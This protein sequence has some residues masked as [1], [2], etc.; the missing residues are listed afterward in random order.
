[1]ENRS[2]REVEM[3]RPRLRPGLRFSL[4]ET[5]GRRVC[6]I[7]DPVAS[8]FHR[9][10]LAEYRFFRE[11]DGAR[12]VASILARLARD[13]GGESFTEQEALQMIRWLKDNHLL[14]VESDRAAGDR[15]HIE[16]A[17]QSAAAW[18]NPLIVKI[19]LARPD[20]FFARVEPSL[21]WALGGFGFILWLAVVLTGATQT[22][23]DWPRFTKGFDGILAR[24]NWVWLFLVWIALK[25]AHEFSHGLFCKHFG[26]SVREIGAILVL[27]V[28]M[29]YVDATASIGLASKWRRIMVSF[30]GLYMEF[31]LAALAAIVWANTG[32]GLANT[33]AHDAVV[34][35][36]VVTLFFNANPLMRFDGYYILGDLFDLPNL[37]SRGRAWFQRSLAWLLAG[38]RELRPGPLRTGEEWV[39]ALYGIASTVWQAVVLAGL[40][41][42]ASVALHGGGALLAAVAAAAWVAIPV[43]RFFASLSGGRWPRVA[44]RS[45]LFLGGLA[46]ALFAPFHRS[47]S[48]PGVVELADTRTLRAE[49]PG[50]VERVNVEDGQ[51][52]HKGQIL[53]ELRN[54]EASALLAKARLDAAQQE[55]RARVAYTEGDISGF[56]AENAKAEALR[57]EAAN[58]ESFL[59]TLTVR[60]PMDGRVTN[61][62]L[63]QMQGS[64]VESGGEMLRIGRPEG[65]DVKIA[66]AQEDEPHLRAAA[67]RPLRVRIEGRGA[68]FNAR[69]L[70]VEARATRELIDPALTALGGGP[71]AVRRAEEQRNEKPQTPE[72]ELAEPRFGATARLETDKPLD[73]GELGRVKFRSPRAATLWGEMQSAFTRWMKRYTARES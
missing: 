45:A 63:A 20:A 13:G 50:F 38:G 3:L 69:L 44:L 40:L 32:P 57:K 68:V 70:R 47:V 46:L 19:P 67:G 4:Q 6:V 59:A 42:G 7:E 15:E 8:R 43:W 23:M 30:A 41:A 54:D 22:A 72:Y 65:N 66:V 31:F 5:G 37:S 55:L 48:S 58:H 17:A 53:L 73:I 10:G 33:L 62:K 18:L 28:P 27:F 35:G 29:G 16:K 56:Q 21:R 26:A 61:R 51:L 14:A 52:V 34:T 36:T 25:S 11:L 49:C 12:T 1:M 64:F 60:A 39:V 24:D 9:A 71:L 2:V